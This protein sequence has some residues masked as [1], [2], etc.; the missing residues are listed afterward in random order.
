MGICAR[1]EVIFPL[2]LPK[3][4][5]KQLTGQRMTLDDI[6]E[7]DYTILK[8]LKQT[9]SKSEAIYEYGDGMSHAEPAQWTTILQDG[10][11]IDL[12][13]DGEGVNENVKFEDRF[14]YIHAVLKA[15]LERTYEQMQEVRRGI[16][17]IIPKSMLNVANMD[18][19]ETWICGN[20][21]PDFELLSRHTVYPA[22]DK[23]YSPDSLLI[24]NFW[25]FLD[26]IGEEDKLKFIM[27]C[28]G[29][30]RLPANDA[31]FENSH[32]QF[33]IKAHSGKTRNKHGRVNMDDCLPEASTCFFHFT[34]PKYTCMEKL[35]EKILIAI[36]YD[37]ISM[38]AEQK[39]NQFHNRGGDEEE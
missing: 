26:E 3:L 22:E 4:F 8:S 35:T 32:I 7:V 23:D 13:G 2:D 21:K 16:A 30:K 31:A 34:L 20:P 38:N 11:E 18:D 10:N 9:F 36:K 1:T 37:C 15:R 5:W 17:Q 24:K 14:K 28:W 27:F 19:L 12:L 33:K 6:A 29:Q 39:S 25:K